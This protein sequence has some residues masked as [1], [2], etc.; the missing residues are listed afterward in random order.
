MSDASE[1][2]SDRPLVQDVEA[3]R[4]AWCACGR[5]AKHPFCDGSHKG[6]DVRPVIVDLEKARKVAWCTCGKTGNAPY[7]DG[8]HKS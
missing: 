5:S 2:R 6:S 4:Y 8:S 1:P 3:G 7:C